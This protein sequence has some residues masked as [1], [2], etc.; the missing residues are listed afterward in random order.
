[1]SMANEVNNLP[2][3]DDT[4]FFVRF[5]KYFIP[6]KG[7]GASEIIRKIVFAFSIVLFVLSLNELTDFLKT[8]QAELN[9]AQGIVKYEPDWDNGL[10]LDNV[11]IQIAVAHKRVA[12][13]I[14]AVG[15]RHLAAGINRRHRRSLGRTAATNHKQAFTR[16][17]V[18]LQNITHAQ[19]IRVIP[20]HLV[21]LLVE[22]VHLYDV[23]V[24]HI[25]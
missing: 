23:L 20:H 16:S 24:F 17:A 3:Q 10:E 22:D 19:I 18:F 12:F 13:L 11:D 1:M 15:H 25:D 7:D 2:E 14:A 5:L 9:Y 21:T 4:N 8:D 6:W